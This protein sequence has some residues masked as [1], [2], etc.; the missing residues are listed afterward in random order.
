MAISNPCGQKMDKAKVKRI[1]VST[2]AVASFLLGAAAANAQEERIKSIVDEVN[3]AN[4]LAVQ[5]QQTIDGVADAT[6]QLFNDYKAVL[7]TNAGLEAYNTQQ[8]RVIVKQEEE[9]AK[10]RT[11]IG[12]IDE[13][14]RQI[15][16]LMLDMIANLEEF[17]NADVPFLLE[18]R[19]DRIQSLRDAMDDPNVSDPERFRIVLEAY[20]T[21]VQ[22][23]RTFF[24]Y[25]GMDDQNRSVNFVRLGRV[26]FYYQTK[27]TTETKAWDGTQ[28]VDVSGEFTRPVR[29]LIRMAQRRTQSDVTIL[30]IAAPGN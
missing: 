15:T 30:P 17:I 9:I 19:L 27:D 4:K 5:S 26:G 2:A 16:P 12:Q 20:K 21:E 25:E 23:G 3:E 24:A 13:I 14:K 7:K 8:R 6:A 22:Y 1:A 11:S 18:E 28:W 29:Q 10:I